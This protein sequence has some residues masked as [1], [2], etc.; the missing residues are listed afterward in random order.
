MTDFEHNSEILIKTAEYEAVKSENI[1][2][3][4]QLAQMKEENDLLSKT[5]KERCV[6]EDGAKGNFKTAYSSFF[7]E[8]CPYMILIFDNKLNLVVGTDVCIRKLGFTDRDRLD[9]MHFEQVFSNSMQLGWIER[10]KNLCKKVFEDKETLVYN[11]K[12]QFLNGEFINTEI[13]I[14][15]VENKNGEMS[16]IL[17]GIQD[18]TEI[19]LEKEKAEEDSLSKGRFLAHMSHEIRTPMSAVKG[20]SELL[21]VTE[22]DKLQSN[23]VTNI[24]SSVNSILKIINN[25]L[26]F[27]KIN[28]K[29]IEIV[30]VPYYTASFLSDVTNMISMRSSEKGL[31]FL[32]DIDPF[33]P[34]VLKGDDIR[35][36][37][38][39][40]N[41]L[42]NAVKYTKKGHINMKVQGLRKRNSIKMI[43]IIEDTGIGIKEDE[44]NMLF[45]AFTQLDLYANRSINGTGLG[46]TI[47]KQLLLLMGG[48]IE[49]ESTYG[50]GSRF[51]F[52][53]NQEIINGEPLAVA[54]EPE[55]KN[56]LL[57]AQGKQGF[58][59]AEMMYKAYLKYEY[60]DSEFVLNHKL[61]KGST[62]T[63]CVYDYEF[64]SRLIEKYS[65]RFSNMKLIAIKD[66]KLA[67]TQITD[68]RIVSLFEPVIITELIDA[69]N[70]SSVNGEG[71]DN[72]IHKGKDF[73]VINA[74]ALVVDDNEVN[75]MVTEELLKQYGFAVTKALNGEEAV[76]KA[77]KNN[78]QII[79]M[80]HMMPG[81]DGIETAKAIRQM[82]AHN[83]NVPIIALTANALTGMKELFVENS[84]DDFISKPVD[85]QE[86]ERIIKE[87]VPE[88]NIIQG[89]LMK[90]IKDFTSVFNNIDNFKSIAYSD[91]TLNISGA[92][93]A[94]N[95]DKNL[96][97]MILS[98]FLKHLESKIDKLRESAKSSDL[99]NFVIYI[100]GMQSSLLNVGAK[101][102]A[103][104]AKKLENA[105]KEGNITYVRDNLK[106][107]IRELGILN[108]K[109][110]IL[111]SHSE[112]AENNHEPVNPEVL[113]GIL[114]DTL[115]MINDLDNLGALKSLESAK[116]LNLGTSET[117]LIDTI[118]NLV[119][120][121]DYDNAVSKIK[122]YML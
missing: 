19:S 58:S 90:D 78:F 23:Y 61:N 105:A 87:W 111:L 84:L 114:Y 115:N 18:I 1:R 122:K 4:Q 69:I 9:S 95:N 48:E 67:S 86:L 99:G 72:K 11:E 75:L 5:L 39:L 119:K 83:K 65:S 35:I 121:Y 103:L 13:T 26:D 79:F 38:I 80:D 41:L 112:D 50:K 66:I 81:M 25:I 8:N 32:T 116:K 108:Q 14:K 117:E 104:L 44:K 88:E 31:T 113:N 33:L 55:N 28:E 46:L 7:M 34:S 57:L 16:G 27:S 106:L 17:F 42:S 74:K 29:K 96:Y 63:H 22:L 70:A 120:N 102:S 6:Q 73:Y 30:E 21:L 43:F 62:Y 49:V 82:N 15:P 59:Y 91:T 93:K 109:I 12:I 94:L 45:D 77:G 64:A 40:I 60:C 92:I 98:N 68:D 10:T 76:L 24:I 20:L 3:R 110:N 85:I 101:E 53:V 97:I 71:D 52:F 47:S 89:S 56:V 100:H 118:K 36:K 107:F 54:K 37:Q 2:L 51:T